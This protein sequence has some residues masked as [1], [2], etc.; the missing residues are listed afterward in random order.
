MYY[1]E[2]FVIAREP[3]AII[4]SWIAREIRRSRIAESRESIKFRSSLLSTVP[5]NEESPET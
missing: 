5:E 2:T 3:R 4:G 1:T